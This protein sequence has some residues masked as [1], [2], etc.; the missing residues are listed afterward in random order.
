MI[1]TGSTVEDGNSWEGLGLHRAVIAHPPAHGKQRQQSSRKAVAH[2]EPLT[3]L[4][5]W[6]S[7]PLAGCRERWGWEQNK[8]WGR[9]RWSCSVH[10]DL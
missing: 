6:V 2:V 7:A 3:N 9:E 8:R 4:L 10:T 5:R 1:Y